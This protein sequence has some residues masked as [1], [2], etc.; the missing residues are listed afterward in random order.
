MDKLATNDAVTDVWKKDGNYAISKSRPN[1]TP[2]TDI[3]SKDGKI[4]VSVKQG[5]KGA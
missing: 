1:R 4:K 5:D 3:I 2:K